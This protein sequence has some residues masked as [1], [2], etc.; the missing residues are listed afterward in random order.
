MLVDVLC[1]L[2]VC[3]IEEGKCYKF[4]ICIGWVDG[5]SWLDFCDD[6]WCV[7]KILFYGWELVD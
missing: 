6:S 4:M 5:V 3:V 7:V 1:V 2:S